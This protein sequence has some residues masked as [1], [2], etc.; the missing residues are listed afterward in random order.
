M[1]VVGGLE[2]EIARSNFRLSITIQYTAVG[3]GQDWTSIREALKQWIVA[4]TPQLP[5]GTHQIDSVASVPF[6][7]HATK[8]TRRP[9]GVFFARWEP[10]D[11]TLPARIREQFDRKIRK[12]EKY[13]ASGNTTVLLVENDDIALMHRTKMLDAIRQAYP[14]GLPSAVNQVWFA[15]TSVPGNPEFTDFS[16]LL[17]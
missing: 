1:Q 4:E 13:S 3:K 12:L 15:D 2:Q 11:N 6:R 8:A 17:A 9:P 5:D 16:G 10:D 14:R 7:I